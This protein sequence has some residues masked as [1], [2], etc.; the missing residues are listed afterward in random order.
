MTDPPPVTRIL[1]PSEHPAEADHED[2]LEHAMKDYLKY[3]KWLDDQQEPM[4]DLVTRWAHV[5]SGSRNIEGL[6]IML[7]H[8]DEAFAVLGGQREFIAFEP[9]DLVTPAGD[10][11]REPLGK[12]LRVRKRPAAAKQVF[13]GIH[14]D[15]VYPPDHEFQ[16][17]ERLDEDRLRGPGVADAKGGLAIMLKALEAFEQCPWAEN[18]GWDVLINP[19]EELGSA[20]SAAILAEMAKG[21]LLGLIFEP[22]FPDGTFVSSR[23]GT[24]NFAAEFHGRAA[25]AGRDVSSGRNAIDAMAEF[26][27]ALNA[28]VAAEP[29]IIVNVA[30]V[31]GGGPINV[32]PDQAF[33][34]FNI[35]VESLSD[36]E[37]AE[38]IIA[39]VTAKID[40]REGFSVHIHGRMMRPPKPLDP[41]TLYW[42]EILA[43]C[44][45][46][47]GMPVAWKP[48]GGASDGNILAAAGLP[49]IDSLG[50]RGD[51][52]HSS[53]EYLIVP[54]LTER[55]KLT[56]LMLM[57]LASG[58]LDS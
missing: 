28:E 21:K 34:G 32:V 10:F 5:N 9:V 49:T 58:A 18:L 35:R 56:A 39:E 19:D 45:A 57:K 42:L 2:G 47:L 37:R 44:G 26:I 25:H 24:G 55:A 48:S 33:C 7:G 14:Y 50:V 31:K 13:L 20:G 16:H 23:K 11:V 30:N 41:K 4:A 3:L 36:R 15:T 54:S 46:E 53:D 40:D 52:L 6:A 22:S 1:L 17:C 43:A 29:G 27:L 8:L 38:S 51:N 12:A